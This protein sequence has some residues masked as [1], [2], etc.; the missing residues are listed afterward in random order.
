MKSKTRLSLQIII[1][2]II[3]WVIFKGWDIEAFCPFGG[4]LSFG[5]QLYQNTM[6]CSMSAVAIFMAF[7]LLIGALAIGKLFCGYLCPIGSISE[8]FYR[9]VAGI[10]GRTLIVNLPGS[11]KAVREGLEVILPALPHAVATL[12]GT[13]GEDHAY[14]P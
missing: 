7:A 2:G 10:R 6:A 11:P 4:I 12:R 3:I 9:G 13:A 5:T 14:H 8:W 1:I